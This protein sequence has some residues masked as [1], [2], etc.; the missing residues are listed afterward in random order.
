M[1]MSDYDV[2]ISSKNISH[3]KNDKS[4]IEYW[5]YLNNMVMVEKQH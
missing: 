2:K 5:T 1:Y 4:N 3:F